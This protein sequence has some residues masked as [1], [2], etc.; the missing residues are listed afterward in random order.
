[1]LPSELDWDASR[2]EYTADAVEYAE[3]VMEEWGNLSAVQQVLFGLTSEDAKAL[4]EENTR[5]LGV[6]GWRMAGLAPVASYDDETDRWWLCFY[7]PNRI[8]VQGLVHALIVFAELEDLGTYYLATSGE[9]WDFG[10]IKTQT[11]EA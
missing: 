9:D 1:M 3:R 7:A 6:V 11:G 8:V 4:T 2:P 5:Q 10:T